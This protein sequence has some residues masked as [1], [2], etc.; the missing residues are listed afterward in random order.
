M[1]IIITTHDGAVY[2]SPLKRALETPASPNHPR[3]MRIKW[4]WERT[5]DGLPRVRS[6]DYD[7]KTHQY[8][9][10]LPDT[11]KQ[12]F[13]AW[14]PLTRLMQKF[15]FELNVWSQYRTPSKLLQP[16]L[17]KAA[18][19]SWKSLTDED[20]VLTNG[21]GIESGYE[22]FVLGINPSSRKGPIQQ[23][24]L[25]LGGNIVHV[26]GSTIQA[27]GKPYLPIQTIDLNKP[28]PTPEY[29]FSQK[30][31]CHWCTI[32]TPFLAARG[33]RIDPFPQFGERSVYMLI[34]K[35]G[36]GYMEE[37]LLEDVHDDVLPSPFNQ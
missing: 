5:S 20:R 16:A 36:I 12:L 34:A 23:E 9:G 27:G 6:L 24:N 8:P 4:D 26:I 21:R 31:L 14:F 28:L 13:D 32:S 1:S 33:Y 25:G 29:L 7:D 11:N 37:R 10:G 17:L 2:S 35:N 3:V 15:W 19:Q 22:D 30:Y 18:K